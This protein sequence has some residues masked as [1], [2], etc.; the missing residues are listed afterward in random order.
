MQIISK[1]Y[2]SV[3]AALAALKAASPLLVSTDKDGEDHLS[4]CGLDADGARFD[5]IVTPLTT[6]GVGTV[7]GP[8]MPDGSHGPDMPAPA[9]PTGEFQ[10]DIY[11]Q[12]VDAPTLSGGRSAD[13]PATAFEPPIPD[14][15]DAP[16]VPS[17]VSLFQGRTVMRATQFAGFPSLFH[18]VDAFVEAHKDDMPTLYDAWNYSNGFD[19]HGA[20][21]GSLGPQFNLTDQILDA[22]FIAA[23]KVRA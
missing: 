23:A 16:V 12:G 2:A 3:D 11:W 19:R 13:A 8:E 21:I 10:V 9:T 17:F 20:M 5:V 18:A 6:P 14:E 1:I 7:P 22:L 15:P 4:P